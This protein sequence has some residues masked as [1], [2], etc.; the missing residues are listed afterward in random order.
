MFRVKTVL[1]RSPIHGFGVLAAEFIPAGTVVW[2]YCEGFD[3][4]VSEEFVEALPEPARS[5]LKHYSALWGGGY[6]ISADDA[7]Y[8]NHSE[9]PNLKTFEDP[10]I[11]VALRDIHIGEELLEDYREF[12]LQE[13][14]L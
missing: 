7:R 2:E 14:H 4:R 8:I 12:D 13:R 5:T 10:D 6:V 3:H 11:D 1:A 9:I